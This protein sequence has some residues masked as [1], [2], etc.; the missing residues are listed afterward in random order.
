MERRDADGAANGPRAKAARG[1]RTDM[2]R[3]ARPMGRREFVRMGAGCAAGLALAGW[4]PALSGC[5]ALTG[6]LRVIED[7]G[8]REVA[9]PESIER[10]FCSNPIGTV[11]IYLLDPDL[12]VGWNFRPTGDNRKYI[13][14]VYLNLPTL[15]VWMGSGATPNDEEIVRQSPQAILCYWTAD[16]VGRSMADDVRDETGVPTLLIDYDIRQCAEMYRY[17]GRLLAREERAE[18]LAAYCAE[19]LAYIRERT[20]QVPAE[21]RKSVYIAQGVGGLS[22]DPVGSMHVTDALELIATDNV[23]DLPGT[24]GQGMGMPTVNL[25]QIIQWDPDAVLV[26]EYSMS[27]SESSDLYG[28]ILADANWRNVPC[29]REGAVYRLPQSPFAWFGRPPSAVRLLGCLLVLKL[30]YPEHTADI[31]LVEETRSF[32]RLFYRIELE[33]EDLADILETAGVDV[34]SLTPG[35]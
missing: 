11:D 34:S 20:A 27:D 9:V 3:G 30:L 35:E 4:M 12:L 21:A 28:E 25:E 22:T 8:G 1:A 14:E 18:E 5:D 13:P 31:D 16:D 15:G 33:D 10:V 26:S 24:A 6:N 29:V 23:A 7:M 17:V 32:Y 19:K 2:A